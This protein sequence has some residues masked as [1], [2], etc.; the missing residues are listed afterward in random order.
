MI[1]AG[2]AVAGGL[3]SGLSVARAAHAFGNETIKIG[4]IGCG[5]RGI[6]AAGDALRTSGPVKLVAVADAFEDSV[7]KAVRG[8]SSSFKDRVDVPQERQFSGFDAYQKVLA[9][10]C[11]L[12]I[13]ATPPGFRPTHFEAA[14]KAG[15]HVFMEKPVATDAR[16]VR[17][18]IAAAAEA[19][20]KGLSVA[21]GLQRRH[22]IAYR[23]T[24]EKLQNG[25]IGDIVTARVY[26][27]GDRPW[28]RPRQKDQT[29]LEY[30]VR[31]WYHF[32]WLSGD[33]ITEQ[34]IHNLDVINWLFNTAPAEAN[35]MGGREVL[36]QKDHGEIFDHHFVE[37]T[38]RIDGREVK[39]FSQCRHQP[40]AWNIVDEYVQGTKGWAHVSGGRIFDASGKVIFH[41]NGKRG[42]HQEEHHHH[43]ADLRKGTIYAEGEYGA[44]SSMTSILGRMA[45]ASGK[46][47]QMKDALDRGITLAKPENF[48]QMSDEAPVKPDSDGYYAIS[49][50]GQTKVLEDKKA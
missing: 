35:G 2:G 5:G 44:M 11:D 47:I 8:L 29:E 41:S 46:V 16:G 30:Q 20:T 43:F 27:N 1:V 14:V 12:V 38:Y 37:Y 23:E 45:T 34:H 39:M 25:I 6:G 9:T 15:K 48:H 28:V 31:N 19:K 32:N 21:V 3:T 26:W 42:G 17:T 33:N 18:V 13:L 50:P 40:G 10:D 36:R 7:S 22:E 4:L 24:I 49:V